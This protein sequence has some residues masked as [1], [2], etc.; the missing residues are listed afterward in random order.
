[1]L[2]VRWLIPL[3]VL[4]PFAAS[5]VT[6]TPTRDFIDAAASRF[7]QGEEDLVPLLETVGKTVF[8]GAHIYHDL[9]SVDND[10]VPFMIVSGLG[11]GTQT[12]DGGFTNKYIRFQSNKTDEGAPDWHKLNMRLV[13]SHGDGLDPEFVNVMIDTPM[14]EDTWY[15]IGGQFTVE[16]DG[17]LT[18]KVYQQEHGGS[19]LTKEQNNI[20]STWE[21]LK[22][23]ALGKHCYDK[24]NNGTATICGHEFKGL[25]ATPIWVVDADETDILKFMDKVHPDNLWA[26]GGADYILQPNVDTLAEKTGGIA[27][28]ERGTFA[29][30][31]VGTL[32]LDED[33]EAP[34]QD[35]TFLGV[36]L[37][38][39]E[40]LWLS[41]QTVT[42][43]DAH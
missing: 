13:T 22:I 33:G 15:A 28:S 2:L 17:E 36:T 3:L 38:W 7:L 12:D 8:F 30:A 32:T 41:V 23:F 10:P 42:V 1:V 40:S 5:A 20:T 16:P 29:G 14:V 39:I 24:D 6:D 26:V 18:V 31:G 21:N 11:D 27:W 35:P 4:M 37:S 43:P 19:L 9:W 25:L 34:V